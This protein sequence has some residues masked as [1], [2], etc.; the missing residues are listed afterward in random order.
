MALRKA[1]SYSKNRVGAFTRKSSIKSKAYIKTVPPK[2]I[3]KF[4]MGKDDV[5]KLKHRLTLVSCEKVQLRQ[6][7][8]ESCRQYLHK[9]LDEKFL[10]QYYFK[11]FPYPHHIQ[12]ENRM[13][14]GAGADRM[15]TGMQLSFGVSMNNA[16]ILKPNDKIFLIAVPNEKA[17]VF[18]REIL[19]KIRAKLPCRTRVDYQLLA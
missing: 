11:I 8:T 6:N 5:S 13:L 18:V 15:S 12:R 9:L 4:C 1:S 7:A 2:I 16:A 17:V 10:G 3:T 14:T 19:G